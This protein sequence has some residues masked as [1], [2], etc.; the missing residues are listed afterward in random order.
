MCKINCD[1]PVR[2]GVNIHFELRAGKGVRPRHHNTPFDHCS[3]VI[4]CYCNDLITG[5]CH[6][7]V[8]H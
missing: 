5:D 2:S 3:A 4:G 6:C 8:I 1:V 7:D